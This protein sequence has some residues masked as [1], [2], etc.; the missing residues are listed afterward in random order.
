[1]KK[2]SFTKQALTSFYFTSTAMFINRVGALIFS[3]LLARF[4][5]PEK[6]GMYNL[7]LSVALIL[8]TFSDLG[9]DTTLTKYLA[10]SLGNK[11][12]PLAKS[13]FKYIMK[14][15]LML[16][17]ITA[18]G[19]MILAYP[20]AFYAFNNS[21][22]FWPLFIA[23]FFI[24][25]NTF[26]GTLRVLFYVTNNVKYFTFKEIISQVLKIALCL[27][28]FFS[29]AEAYY[30][31]GI[32]IGLALTSLVVLLYY[33][34]FI[35]KFAGVLFTK[36]KEVEINKKEVLKFLSYLIIGS[37]SA[38][39]FSYIDTIVLG[40]YL[41]V[42]YVGYYRAAFGIIFSLSGFLTFANVLFPFFNRMDENRLN[43]SIS[44]ILRY[45]SLVTIPSVFGL[46]VLSKYITVLMYG[47]EYLPSA[48]ALIILSPLLFE[49]ATTGILMSFYQSKGEVK[50]YTSMV[51]LSIFLNLALALSAVHY[52]S[53][54]IG[55]MNGVAL[56]TLF[57]RYLLFLVL[58]IHIK[59]KFKINLEGKIFLKPIVASLLMAL[60]IYFVNLKI[61]SMNL[62][63]GAMDIILGVVVYF[64]VM[65]IIKGIKKEDVVILRNLSRTIH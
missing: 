32:F 64:G 11:N 18:V 65:L 5:M 43:N 25:F 56:A 63:Y 39:F 62:L 30:V 3:I 37:I 53:S 20:L 29:L 41:P 27:I 51:V 1:M 21:L 31:S 47:Y 59:R 33:M 7:V 50:F 23:G 12:Y 40:L 26:E 52:F 24:F 38:V 60:A 36:Q 9:I 44:K 22:L 34:L 58:M 57:T 42:E 49:I 54:D 8:I 14:I 28:V 15:K 19:L 61:G 2:E 10:N 35:K 55:A 48:Y 16:A 17:G 4:L 6:F 46:I 45:T 13:Y